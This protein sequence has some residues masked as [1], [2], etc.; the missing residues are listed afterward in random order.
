MSADS[1]AAHSRRLRARRAYE[2]LR[3]RVGPIVLVALTSLLAGFVLGGG[4]L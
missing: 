2:T 1:L 4:G 3:T